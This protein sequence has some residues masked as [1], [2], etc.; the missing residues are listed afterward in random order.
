MAFFALLPL[1]VLLGIVVLIVRLIDARDR[2]PADSEG[3][4]AR[5]IFR[6]LV[7]LLTLVLS[8]VGLAGLADAAATSGQQITADTA[9]VALSVAFV[10][11]AVPAFMVLAVVTR[12]RLRDDPAEAQSAGWALYL[13]LV[14]FGSLVTSVTLL[15]TLFG[16]LL[17]GADPPGSC[18]LCVEDLAPQGKDGLGLAV[19]AALGRSAR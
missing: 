11:V 8:C 2:T 17:V 16:D 9:S 1:L 10:V 6:Y 12:R 13:T 3:V 4:V 18:L 15:I 5:G 7:M 19:A 14:L